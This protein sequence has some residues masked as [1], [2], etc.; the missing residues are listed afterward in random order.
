MAWVRARE[1]LQGKG[2][3]PWIIGRVIGFVVFIGK[4]LPY[5]PNVGRSVEDPPKSQRL[6]LPPVR[7]VGVIEQ[8]SIGCRLAAAGHLTDLLQ[9][10]PH[11]VPRPGLVDPRRNP[12][13]RPGP[14]H[15]FTALCGPKGICSERVRNVVGKSISE[16]VGIALFPTSCWPKKKSLSVIQVTSTC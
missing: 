8:V 14:Y 3:P 7:C 9:Q 11:Q 10:E 15:A 2:L 13:L 4:H 16:G 12:T 5:I 6:Y 1:V